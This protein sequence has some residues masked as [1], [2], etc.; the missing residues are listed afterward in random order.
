MRISVSG[1]ALTRLLLSRVCSIGQSTRIVDFSFDGPDMRRNGRWRWGSAALRQT[2]E[3][4]AETLARHLDSPY[5]H[6]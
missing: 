3:A 2:L 4:L 1:A 6:L 5:R